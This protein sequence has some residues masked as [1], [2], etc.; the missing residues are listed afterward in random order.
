MQATVYANL[1]NRRLTTTL[2]GSAVSFPAF[3][4]GDQVRIGLRFAESLEGSRIEVQRAVTHIRA[5]IGFVDARPT[6]GLF[7]LKVDGQGTAP[8]PHDATAGAVQSAL[9]AIGLADT[10]VSKQ[11][12]SWIIS[13]GAEDIALSGISAEGL[14]AELR[15]VSFVRVRSTQIGGQHRHEVRLVQAPITL[16][17]EINWEGLEAAANIDWLRPSDGG[18]GGKPSQ[19][20]NLLIS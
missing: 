11:D 15:P 17:L 20:G 7:V 1:T 9:A 4:Q 5:S 18:T 10:V 13:T 12:G 8:I 14:L 3:V 2:G 6:S 16:I 19:G